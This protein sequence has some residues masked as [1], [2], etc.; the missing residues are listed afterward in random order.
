M[1]VMRSAL[2]LAS[3]NVWLREHATKYRFV[4]GAV[5]RFM[6]GEEL[7]DALGAAHALENK[8]LGTILT[9][10]G[11]NI[12]D[13]AEAGSVTDHY[14]EVLRQIRAG[15][16]RTEISVKPTQ[17]GLDLSAELCFKNLKTL[18]LRFAW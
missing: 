13:A 8:G 2:L 6:P 9:H 3:Q 4:R 14:L 7:A 18:I 12:A 1:G 5:S 15:S 16:W 11:E 17:L 10:L